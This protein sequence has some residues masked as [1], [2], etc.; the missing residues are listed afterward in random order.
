MILG[1]AAYMAPEQARGNRDRR[2]DIWA[3]GV[4]LYEMLTGARA[5]PVRTP[6]TRWA[7]VMESNP[8]GT[9]VPADVAAGGPRAAAR[10]PRARIRRHRVVDISI[11]LYARLELESATL[12]RPAAPASVAHQPRDPPHLS[13]VGVDRR[14]DCGIAARHAVAT[15]RSWLCDALAPGRCRLAVSR[16]TMSPPSPAALSPTRTTG[17][18]RSR[19]TATAS[20][21]S[22]YATAAAASSLR[23]LDALDP[24]AVFTGEGARRPFFSPDGQWIGFA[25]GLGMLKKVAITGGPA[26]TLATLD[27]A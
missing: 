2:A 6:P 22:A 24:V 25:D 26:I 15:R 5:S 9:R 20:S 27:A 11:A 3:F 17:R 21:M 4:V 7:A 18:S 10:L 16:L 19:R 1:T 14:C 12:S 23:A 8:T 13:V